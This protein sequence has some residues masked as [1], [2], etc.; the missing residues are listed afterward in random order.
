M[1]NP[2]HFERL[3]KKGNPIGQV[4]AVDK[5]LIKVRGLQPCSLHALVMF[6]DG[7]K[8]FVYEIKS[9]YVVVLHLGTKLL[10]PGTVAVIQHDQL[11]CRVGKDFVGRVVSV[12]GD[13]MDGKG[14]I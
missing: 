11:F 7:S 5:F 6:D 13:P 4:I 8:G 9:H 14:P 2:Q 12:T 3:V 10:R 1:S